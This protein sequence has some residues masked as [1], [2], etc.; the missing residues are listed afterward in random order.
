MEEQD[1]V[2]HFNKEITKNTLL[3][4]PAE[5]FACSEQGLEN[6]N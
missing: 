3:E 6:Q 2:E 5:C 1:K 4:R